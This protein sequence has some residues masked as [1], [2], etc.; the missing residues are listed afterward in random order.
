M[1]PERMFQFAAIPSGVNVPHYV[2][3]ELEDALWDYW[4]EHCTK[5]YERE[6]ERVRRRIA[7]KQNGWCSQSDMQDAGFVVHVGVIGKM[8]PPEVVR[9]RLTAILSKHCPC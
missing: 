3:Q 4:C 9:Q 6:A 2:E 8:V 7:K 1:D 5:G